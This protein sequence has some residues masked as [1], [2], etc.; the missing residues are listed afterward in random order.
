MKPEFGKLRRRSCFVHGLPRIS[1]AVGL[2]ENR[3]LM[4]GLEYG[5]KVLPSI[6]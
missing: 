1:K 2:K 4:K 5:G 3:S 6:D